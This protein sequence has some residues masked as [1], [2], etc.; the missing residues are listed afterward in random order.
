MSTLLLIVVL[1]LGPGITGPASAAETPGEAESP[2]PVAP[3]DNTDA[4][5]ESPT[6]SP[7]ESVPAEAPVELEEPPS[8]AP[9][10]PAPTEPEES[11]SATPEDD[12]SAAQVE[13]DATDEEPAPQQRMQRNMGGSNTATVEVKVG[14]TR[15]SVGGNALDGAELGIFRSLTASSPI[16]TCRSSSGICTL[17]IPIDGSSTST[18]YFVKAV[19]APAGYSVVGDLGVTDNYGQISRSNYGF[20]VG[21]RVCSWYRPCTWELRSGKTYRSYPTGRQGADFMS[22]DDASSGI[23]PFIRDNPSLPSQCGMDVAVILD[24]STSMNGS[25]DELA[26]TTNRVVD[27]LQ[28]T[29]STVSM[30]NFGTHSPATRVWGISDYTAPQ[31]VD[32]R[33]KADKVRDLYSARADWWSSRRAAKF[34]ISSYGE[35]T[36]WDRGL[37]APAD[38]PSSYDAAVVLT[39]GNPTYHGEPTYY[40]NPQGNGAHTRFAEVEHAI[41]SANALK[42]K[43]THVIAV[44]AGNREIAGAVSRSN[45][46]AISGSGA[47]IQ[48]SD[49]DDAAE[50][51]ANMMKQ[52]CASSVAVDKTWVIN[53]TEYAQGTQPEGIDA[54]LFL[55]APGDSSGKTRQAAWGQEREGYMAGTQV[56][57]K[58]TLSISETRPG[59]Q[60]KSSEVTAVGPAST[61]ASLTGGYLSKALSAGVTRFSVTS[62][63]ICEQ[64]LTLTM[65]AKDKRADASRWKLS[66]YSTPEDPRKGKPVFSGSQGVKSH[67]VAAGQT[68]QL[69]AEQGPEVFVQDDK[70]SNPSRAPLA[71]G[72]WT[73]VHSDGR[74]SAPGAGLPAGG[75][76]GTVQV[77]LGADLN[78]TATSRTAEATLLK[79]VVNEHGGTI[80]PEDFQ[81]Q[82]V[83]TASG[84]AL[85][86][87]TVPGSGAPSESTAVLVRP[88]QGYTISEESLVENLAFRTGELQRYTGVPNEAIDHQ[89]ARL[90]E[91]VSDGE[92]A[93]EADGAE[94]YRLVSYDIAPSVLPQTGGLGSMPYL[95]GGGAMITLAALAAFKLR[96]PARTSRRRAA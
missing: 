13:D 22:A 73:C 50:E 17:E 69:A 31:P 67:S 83:P 11:S 10:S 92:I 41:F 87:K 26:E 43:G 19:T 46:L 35:G 86:S 64:S 38:A 32:T 7:S 24:L 58:E 90:W 59:C 47:M 21:E 82:A 39:D 85:A 78:C 75:E 1:A 93:V 45:L 72:S 89:D 6:P 34:V 74:G 66:A 4:P 62:T 30:F 61:S 20:R 18:P 54:E 68:L 65:E 14:E 23:F 3:D 53:G 52:N 36:N 16:T 79:H 77:P 63:V 33:E 94:I 57:L 95:L 88:A 9:E 55:S 70:R 84:S 76:D 91:T 48:Q 44:G 28:G 81:L 51:L 60:L 49:F 42:A 80:A 15:G 40:G 56:R 5:E 27:E 71:T 12:D 2:A 25:E 96:H 29:P 37:S 8:E